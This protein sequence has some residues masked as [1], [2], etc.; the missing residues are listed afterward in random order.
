MKSI[1]IYLLAPFLCNG[2]SAVSQDN[3]FVI[4]RLEKQYDLNQNI[5]VLVLDQENP[6]L[7]TVQN[8]FWTEKFIAYQSYLDQF[9]PKRK[10]DKQA[11]L[12]A[13]NI[14]WARISLINKLPANAPLKNYFLFTGKS[15]NT[16]VYLTDAE[17]EVLDSMFSGYLEPR[18]RKDFQFGNQ[19]TDRVQISLPSADTLTLY[20]KIQA[21]NLRPP[22]LDVRL[23]REDFFQNWNYIIQT[24]K[25]W[26]FNGFLLTLFFINLLLFF[27]TRDL[28]FLYHSLFQLGLFLYLLEFFFV[29]YDL[30]LIRDHPYWAQTFIYTILCGMDLAFLQFIRTFLDLKKHYPHLEKIFQ[31]AVWGRI[32]LLI[33]ALTLYYITNN[34]PL[35]DNISALYVTLQ[36]L[37]VIVLLWLVKHR[38]IWRF[39][40]IGG[41]LMVTLG[42]ILNALSIIFGA[43]VRFSYTQI[44]V[45]GELLFFTIGLG[46]RMK[47]LIEE[48]RNTA[49]LKKM[50]EFKTRFYTNITHEFRTPLTVIQGFTDQ[51]HSKITDSE[52]LKDLAR[53][54]IHSVQLAKLVDRMLDLSKLQSGETPLKLQQSDIISFIRYLIFSF[55][56]FAGNRGVHLRFLT[57]LERFEMDFD[58]EKLQDVLTNLISNAI[59]F[60]DEGGEIVVLVKVS[61]KDGAQNFLIQVKDRGIGM[62]AEELKHIFDRFYQGS[63]IRKKGQGSGLGLAITR[64]LIKLM[65]GRIEVSSKKGKGSTFS[66][67]HP[68]SRLAPRKTPEKPE[69]FEPDIEEKVKVDRSE[70]FQGKKPIALIVEDNYDVLL[71]L[72]QLLEKEYQIALAY[73]GVEGIRKAISLIPDVVISDVIMPEKDGLE[74]CQTLKTD[75]R[76]NHIPVVLL[77]AKASVEDK[78]KG[79]RFGA[80]AYLAKPFNQEELF[81][82]LRN[83]IQ[84]RKKLQERYG[85]RQKPDDK[86]ITIKNAAFKESFKVQ[87]AFLAKIEKIVLANLETE[88]FSAAQLAKA[89]H[90]SRSQLHRKIS[91]LTGQSVSHFINKIRLQKAKEFLLNTE[92]T[93]AE[94]A[95]RIGLEPNYFSRLFRE[96]IGVP[97]SEFLN[98]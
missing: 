67:Y 88:G 30:P 69:S 59:K 40:I 50:D 65:G 27:A 55:Q 96:E 49:I 34:M 66:V 38:A 32:S 36:Y 29:L 79:L 1:Y 39:F 73:N 5:Y 11:K 63:S 7:T 78:L 87:D 48:E 95:Y 57:E 28:V 53:I 81:L 18:G 70:T 60:T 76:T 42:V 20:I 4:D 82:C 84:I 24:R 58:A 6:P 77:T 9:H 16:T 41:A 75:E 22:W 98:R 46:Y 37:G 62:E 47:I 74:L 64:E 2:F 43:G 14:Y 86:P 68:I 80:D 97:P 91:A 15:E 89:S 61:D 8:T 72:S 83:F 25:D 19:Q 92:L 21:D 44:G 71:Y 13:K 33:G 51:L 54:K 56:S 45:F 94:I 17:G 12:D 52:K 31:L 35:A 26:T 85:R 93:V 10:N 90:M 23:S 3:L